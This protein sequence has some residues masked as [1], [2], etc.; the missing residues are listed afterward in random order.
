MHPAT[1]RLP[2]PAEMVR[3]AMKTSAGALAALIVWLAAGALTPSMTQAQTAAPRPGATP[4]APARVA[5]TASAEYRLGTGDVIRVTVF[6]NP[7][8]TTETRISETGAISFPLINSVRIGGLTSTEAENRIAEAL[9]TGNFVKQPQ[10]SLLV[11][12]VRANQVSV[13]GQVGRPGRYPIETADFRL[14]ELLA[15]AGGV[16]PA[17]A[18]LVTITGTRNGQ[19]FRTEVDMTRLFGNATRTDDLLL[20]NGDVVW[21]DR[22]PS[23]YIYGEVQRPGVMR[24]ERQMTV[25]QALATGGGLTQRGTERGMRLHRRGADGKINI[26]TPTMDEALKDGDVIYVRE[27]IF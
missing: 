1:T 16:N 26:T 8:L 5:S 15:T 9:R 19:P 7:D 21:V 2:N 25:L 18:D 3:V 23:I 14:T 12:Q 6:Q 10:V 13:L 4:A 24:L 20:Q 27:S 22:S 17:G 11:L